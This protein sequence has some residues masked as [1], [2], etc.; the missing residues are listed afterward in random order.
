MKEVC[1]G[2]G[3]PTDHRRGT[4]ARPHRRLPRTRA[5]SLLGADHPDTVSPS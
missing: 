4:E 3:D 1:A 2:R 5:L